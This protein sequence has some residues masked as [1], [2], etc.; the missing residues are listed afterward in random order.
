MLILT[1]WQWWYRYGWQAAGRALLGFLSSTVHNFSVPILVRTLLAPWKRTVNV[2]GPNTPLE[3]RLQWW[4]GNQVSRFIGA[5]VRIAALVTAAIIL[6]LTALAGGILLL[7]WPLV[8]L[9]VLGGVIMA[10][11]RLWM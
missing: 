2:A 5:F 4:V 8:P 7:L 9:A 1:L 3:V 10:G 6:G 11:V